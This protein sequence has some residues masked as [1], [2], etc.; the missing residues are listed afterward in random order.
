MT[1]ADFNN[2]HVA[3]TY[4][5]NESN[6]HHKEMSEVLHHDDY[7]ELLKYYQSLRNDVFKDYFDQRPTGKP[8]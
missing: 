2:A 5:L 1:L 7:K 6:K 3:Y 8:F 4:I